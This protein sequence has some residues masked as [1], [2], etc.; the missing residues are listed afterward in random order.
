M[1]LR[2]KKFGNGCPL[3]VLHGLYGSSD[4][5]YT[6]G[7]KLS[8]YFTVYLVDQRNHGESPHHP[9]LNYR[10]MTGDLEE[11]LL[12]E[13]IDYACIM[14]HSMGGKV[15]LNYT[16]RHPGK[17]RKL[18]V[19]DIA[20]RSYSH[21][22]NYAPQAFFHRKIVDS[23]AELDISKTNT[24]SVIDKDLSVNIPQKPLRQFLLKNLKRNHKGKFYWALN[25]PSLRNN[26]HKLLDGID[27]K[28]M[29]VDIP[30]MVISGMH[31]AYI[32]ENDKA[33][34]KKVFPNIRVVELDSGHW[35]HAEQP[36]KL[37]DLLVDFLPLE[38]T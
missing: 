3:I 33:M 7:K 23:L 34:F 2:Y 17:V 21:K 20:L 14:G 30:V 10:V 15:A 8:E 9:E 25:I 4:N 13:H 19:I 31:S 36:V 6:F 16:L 26:L 27:A 22:S 28:G 38:K 24:R 1:L 37:L 35:V 12:S 18:V 29:V 11:L 32:R 5:W